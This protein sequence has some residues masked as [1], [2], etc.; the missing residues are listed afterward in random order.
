MTPNERVLLVDNLGI[1]Y[2]VGTEWKKAVR[3]VSFSIGRGESLGLVCEAG[4][5]K[6]TVALNLAVA[7]A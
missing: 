3:D 7:L 2:K 1:E 5:G 6:T 4:C